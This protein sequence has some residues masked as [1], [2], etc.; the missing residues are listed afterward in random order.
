MSCLENNGDVS[1]QTG[2]KHSRTQ[3][4]NSRGRGRGRLRLKNVRFPQSYS[5]SSS[6]SNSLGLERKY[7][8]S[9]ALGR[10]STSSDGDARLGVKRYL[11]PFRI[12]GANCRAR[13]ILD[14]S[15]GDHNSRDRSSR[16]RSNRNNSGA[17][18][19]VRNTPRSTHIPDSNRS[20]DRGHNSQVRRRPGPE[21]GIQR[22]SEHRHVRSVQRGTPVQRP[23]K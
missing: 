8:R 11:P 2:L 4:S 15:S 1:F 16:G 17:A 23:Q 13:N 22:Q 7:Q 3:E 10:A 14:H 6:S 12:S 5:C 9:I 20:R 18:S 21:W 19:R